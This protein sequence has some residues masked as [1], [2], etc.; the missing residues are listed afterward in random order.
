M[1]VATVLTNQG[2]PLSPPA[3]ANPVPELGG[4]IEIQVASQGTGF[5]AG[6]QV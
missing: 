1:P 4:T 2:P 5:E 6:P 3:Q